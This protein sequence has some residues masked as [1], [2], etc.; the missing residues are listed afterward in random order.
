[1]EIMHTVHMHSDYAYL[2]MLNSLDDTDQDKNKG[3][4]VAFIAP[5]FLGCW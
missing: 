3:S 1:M 2:F 5:T 4:I